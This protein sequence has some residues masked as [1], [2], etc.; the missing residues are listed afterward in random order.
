MTDVGKRIIELRQRKEWSQYKLYKEAGIGQ[1]TLSEIESGK[2]APT[3]TTLAKICQAL[4]ISLADF[5]SEDNLSA[6]QHKN[7]EIDE[8]DLPDHIKKEIALI[9]EFVLYKHGIKK[10]AT[11]K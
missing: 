8:E 10:S 5:F 9:K 6:V 4:E 2:K 11:D 3:V 1:T 7:N